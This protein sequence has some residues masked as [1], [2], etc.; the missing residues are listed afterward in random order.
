ME[1]IIEERVE[2]DELFRTRLNEIKKT[3]SQKCPGQCFST[4]L[5]EAIRTKGPERLKCVSVV[6]IDWWLDGTR[7]A[8]PDVSQEILTIAHVIVENQADN[9]RN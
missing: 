8:H 6:I 9:E 4:L 5:C 3:F 2:H 1:I 7:S